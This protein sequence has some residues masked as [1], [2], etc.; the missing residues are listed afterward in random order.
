MTKAGE[1]LLKMSNWY[2]G[3]RATLDSDSPESVDDSEKDYKTNLIRG[4]L[5]NAQYNLDCQNRCIE[6]A[7]IERDLA[8]KEVVQYSA[9]LDEIKADKTAQKEG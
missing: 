3:L 6:Q 8:M 4:K 1:A 2:R 9:W 5:S 7:V